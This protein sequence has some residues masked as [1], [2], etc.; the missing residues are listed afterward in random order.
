[1]EIVLTIS[2][3]QSC[4]LRTKSITFFCLKRKK[5]RK[6]KKM[7]K[8]I[9]EDGKEVANFEVDFLPS[10]LPKEK[11][12]EDEEQSRAEESAMKFLK[13]VAPKFNIVRKQK[14]LIDK[15]KPLFKLEN[16][17][18]QEQ[19]ARRNSSYT[20]KHYKQTF[21]IFNEFLAYWYSESADEFDKIYG[22]CPQGT[23][24][25]FEFYGKLFPIL[26][27]DNE[28]L[29]L[30]FGRYL[31][32]VREVSEQTVL[33][34]FRDFRAFMYYAMDCGCTNRRNITIREVEPPIKEVYNDREI[35][36]LLRAPTTDDYVDNR[37]WV[38]VNY[39][40]GTGNRLQTIINLKV[41]DIELESGYVNINVQKNKHT[42]R[43]GLP[44]RLVGVLRNYIADYRSDEN[45]MPLLNS[46][47]F[48]TQYGEKITA[49][50]LYKSLAHY[51]RSRGVNKTSIHLFRHTFAK[52]WILDGGDV[53]SLQKALGHSNLKMA[54]RYA[55][56]YAQ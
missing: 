25:P 1:M 43:L 33:T 30:D 37:N 41:G 54:Q 3:P 5:E 47:L 46:Y 2:R 49:Q 16:A 22:T 23:K 11:E 55:N 51:I 56:L 21:R 31:T 14:E 8:K 24:N 20:I 29:Q 26:V 7:A 38:I 13:R 19:E 48:A 4:K 35:K 34:Y 45:G 44:S 39:L 15:T 40:L 9:F 17:F 50:G 32:E 6:K 27:L 42:T 52:M 18:I 12:K 28:E 53:L 36:A 10:D